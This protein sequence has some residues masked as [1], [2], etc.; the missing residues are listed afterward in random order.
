MDHSAQSTY[1]YSGLDEKLFYKKV[2]KLL[3][4]AEPGDIVFK[5]GDVRDLTRANVW[6]KCM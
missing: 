2:I 6:V 1:I 5:N 4:D 3:Y